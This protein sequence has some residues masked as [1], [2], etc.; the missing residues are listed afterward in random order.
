MIRIYGNT[1]NP[2]IS[3]NANIVNPIFDKIYGD[4]LL[5][6]LVYQK[7]KLSLTNISLK[8]N[9]GSY[10]GTA[11]IPCK[12]DIMNQTLKPILLNE[13]DLSITEVASKCANA[14]A[15]AGSVKSSAGT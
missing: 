10:F 12:I 4:K 9:Q 2:R 5:V 13:I 6:D 1:I 15:G 8:T 11:I 3:C 7:D 14:A